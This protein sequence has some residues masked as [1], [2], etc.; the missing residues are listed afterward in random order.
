MFDCNKNASAYSNLNRLLVETVI[1]RKGI[2]QVGKNKEEEQHWY[3]R[4]DR[5][6]N[7]SRAEYSGMPVAG[8]PEQIN[9]RLAAVAIVISGIYAL[10]EAQC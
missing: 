5:K 8:S 6:S 10:Y 4:I 9:E 7:K 3:E 1:T 2:S